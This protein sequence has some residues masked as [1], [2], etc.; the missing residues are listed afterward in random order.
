MKKVIALSFIAILLVGSSAFAQQE[1]AWNETKNEKLSSLLEKMHEQK[2]FNGVVLLAEGGNVVFEVAHGVADLEGEKTL[3]ADSSFRLASVSKQFT[4]MAI[5][6]LQEQGKLDYDDDIR[7][8]LPELKYEGVTIRHLL[9]HTGGLPDY[10]SWFDENWDTE[11]EFEDKK[12]A[13]NKDVVEQF[14]KHNPAPE[15]SPG[16]RWQYSNTGYVLL[17]HIIERAS[18]VATRD[19]MAQSIFAPLE[20]NDT[21]AFATTDEFD[22]KC[23]V[24]G[25]ERLADG[26]LGSND[27]NFLNG[28]I[29]D[30][31]V[32]ASAHDLLKWDQG[33][34][35]EKL[36]K[37]ETLAK[38]FTQGKTNDGE[39][40][41]YGFGWG[42]EIEDGE[43]VSV[44]HS[45]GW[46]GF[47]TFISRD[48][49]NK[50]TVILLTNDSSP[51]FG[52]VLRAIDSVVDGEDVKAPK[53]SI[54]YVLADVIEAEGC[55]VASQR[56]AELRKGE[57]RRINFDEPN[58]TALA[59]LYRE[60]GDYHSAIEVY[61]LS[62][63]RFE[64]SAAAHK[65][66]GVCLIEL[67]KK[68]LNQSIELRPGDIA[69]TE[70][71][72]QL[73]EDV[74]QAPELTE[75][76]LEEYVGDYELVPGF[77]I[78]IRRDGTKITGQPTGQSLVSLRLVAADRFSI[79]V[80]DAQIG[81]NRDDEG[82]V[83]SLTL[84]Q[85]GV[86]QVGKR[87]E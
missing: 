80:V 26:S 56:Y 11:K 34:Y 50:R 17:G 83:T 28:M 18:G 65:G 44:S 68:H 2:Q 9:N 58:T 14:G 87:M 45:G 24:F 81:F 64:K 21:Q 37:N 59:D 85:G 32:Y 19:F 74:V 52:D 1:S 86:E 5:M 38:A 46:V 51:H 61:R 69:T 41:D 35:T 47:R 33:L 31:G 49:V 76:Q 54:G 57:R 15:F 78:S 13:Y 63:E 79:D 53:V 48:L 71:L 4:A 82:K 36:V 20:M 7:K 84:F 77:T 23:K 75:E 6:I 72:T 12:T 27:W 62:L 30:G 73:G 43:P 3:D 60:R 66:L 10:E 42:V 67:A 55:Q 40:T 70:L 25:M 8:H 22:L 29:G 39:S 16:E